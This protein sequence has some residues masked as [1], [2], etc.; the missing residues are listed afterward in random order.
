MLSALPDTAVTGNPTWAFADL[1]GKKRKKNK[2]KLT[3]FRQHLGVVNN[4][5]CTVRFQLS[6]FIIVFASKFAPTFFS[7]LGHVQIV[8]EKYKRKRGRGLRGKRWTHDVLGSA[9]SPDDKKTKKKNLK[10]RKKKFSFICLDLDL[11][12]WKYYSGKDKNKV[13][14]YPDKILVDNQ[15]H[16]FALLIGADL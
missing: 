7:P 9:R 13:C 3:F 2:Q 5:I 12:S 15:I 11:S 1:S 10:L 8:A 14:F 6:V 16:F 4:N